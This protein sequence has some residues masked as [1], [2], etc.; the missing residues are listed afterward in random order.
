MAV[1]RPLEYTKAI[2]RASAARP[3]TRQTVT[4]L[5]EAKMGDNARVGV[6]TVMLY[7]AEALEACSRYFGKD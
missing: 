5:T 1:R 6:Y 7:Q 3:S 2:R 4:A